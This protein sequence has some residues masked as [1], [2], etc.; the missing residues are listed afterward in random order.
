M[1]NQEDDK[2]LLLSIKPKYAEKIFSGNKRVELRR[3]KPNVKKGDLVAVYVSSPVMALM[4]EFEV[5]AVMKNTP[6]ALWCEVNNYAG[7]SKSEYDEYY[8][9]SKT[10]FG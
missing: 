6:R 9:G 2:V 4:G 1:R 3:T 7:V 10:A 5:E 8:E